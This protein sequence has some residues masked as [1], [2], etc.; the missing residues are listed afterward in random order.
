MSTNACNRE[1]ETPGSPKIFM[2]DTPV[3]SL[4]NY[5]DAPEALSTPVSIFLRGKQRLKGLSETDGAEAFL[6]CIR[7]I[8]EERIPLSN[9]Q[10]HALAAMLKS[11]IPFEPR[12]IIEYD[13]E[14]ITGCLEYLWETSVKREKGDLMIQCGFGYSRWEEHHLRFDH[15]REILMTLLNVRCKKTADEATFNNNIGFAW[16]LEGQF[17]A[18][19]PWFQKAVTLHEKAGK[20]EEADNSRL[21]AISSIFESAGIDAIS[22]NLVRGLVALGQALREKGDWRCRKAF[23]LLAR[24]FE[25]RGCLRTAQLYAR[26]AAWASGKVRT[27]YAREDEEYL[28]RLQEEVNVDFDEKK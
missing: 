15:S 17:D 18:A 26:E 1:E 2:D 16:F 5:L 8:Y 7:T 9:R 20:H 3:E 24:T 19:V 4:L 21:N 11:Y 6:H 13:R 22:D 28:R 12:P 10:C 23:H 25:A 27:L 14:E